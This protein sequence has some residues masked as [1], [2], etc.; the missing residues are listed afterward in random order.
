MSSNNLLDQAYIAK[1]IKSMQN[2]AGL[3]ETG[4]IDEETKNLMNS[5][6]CG[7]PDVQSHRVKRY[8]I[9]KTKWPKKVTDT[10]D[11]KVTNNGMAN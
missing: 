2:F 6:R 5:E 4:V 3:K 10:V 9:H 11:D 8:V 7:L 1:A